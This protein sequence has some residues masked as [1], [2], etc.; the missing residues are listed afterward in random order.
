[1]NHA[2]EIAALAPQVRPHVAIVTAIEP[3]HLEFFSGLEAI[4]DAKAEIFLGLEPGGIAVVNRDTPHF[5]RLKRA[6]EAAGA[7]RVLG[8]GEHSG[9]EARLP[10]VALHPTCSCIS[11]EIDGQAATY[12]VGAPGRHRAVNSM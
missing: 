6:A 1:M 8:F 12:K 9:A 10:R 11:S 3:V 2:G 5:E 7:A 4:A